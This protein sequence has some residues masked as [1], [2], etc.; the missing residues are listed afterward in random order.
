[1]SNSTGAHDPSARFAGTS[2]SMTMGRKLLKLGGEHRYRTACGS[3][4]AI[5]GNSS[6]RIRTIT[7]MTM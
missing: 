1:M 2:P 5:G 3:H 4:S 7:W 6:S